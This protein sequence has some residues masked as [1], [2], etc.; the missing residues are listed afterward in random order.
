MTPAPPF[1][2]LF[3]EDFDGTGGVTVVQENEHEPDV[4]VPRF[5]PEEIQAAWERGYAEGLRDGQAKAAAV[6]DAAIVQ[7][8]SSVADH[9]KATRTEVARITAE[10]AASV[11]GTLMAALG[12]ALPTVCG[13]HGPAEVAAFARAILPA[14]HREPRVTI[15]LHP[16]AVAALQSEINRLDRDVKDA[17]FITPSDTIAPADIRIVWQDATAVCDVATLWRSVTDA[18]APLGLLR[19]TDLP[20]PVPVREVTHG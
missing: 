19:A 1:G 10:A 11:A 20:D 18:L 6:Q 4:I 14:L 3:P 16:G 9:L 8:L 15:R 5:G 13:R 7:I 17:I 12:V 2:L